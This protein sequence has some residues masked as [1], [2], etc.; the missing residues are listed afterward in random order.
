MVKNILIYL[1]S[2]LILFFSIISIAQGYAF[3]VDYRNSFTRQILI[4][5]DKTSILTLEDD[6][7]VVDEN[8]KTVAIIYP[9]EIVERGFWSQS[10]SD[11]VFSSV[12]KGMK[13]IKITLDSQKHSDIRAE[14]VSEFKKI[15]EWEKKLRIEDLNEDIKIKRKAKNSHETKL[16]YL[17]K[18]EIELEKDLSDREEDF[19]REASHI[20]REIDEATRDIYQLRYEQ[21]ELRSQ[22]EALYQSKA[23][24]GQGIDETEGIKNI[25]DRIDGIFREIDRKLRDISNLRDRK[26]WYQSLAESARKN[27]T[28]IRIDIREEKSMLEE[29]SMELDILVYELNTLLGK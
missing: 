16:S 5:S 25:T 18:R 27:L 24:Q 20:D 9:N 19:F 26:R 11:E 6:L 8:G 10:L 7:A 29:V 1:T 4:S 21:E 15:K 23:I 3:L 17:E 13:V 14:G 12:K 28:D 2:S 22:R